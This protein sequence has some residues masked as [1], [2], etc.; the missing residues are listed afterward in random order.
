MKAKIQEILENF[1]KERIIAKNIKLKSQIAKLKN[2]EEIM[3]LEIVSSENEIKILKNEIIKVQKQKKE[4][5][6]AYKHIKEEHRKIKMLLMQEGT[7][8]KDI[9]NAL[10]V[11]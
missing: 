4:Y 7:T 9:K 8:L 6:A 1:E 11:K 10:G 2:L 3:G 5:L